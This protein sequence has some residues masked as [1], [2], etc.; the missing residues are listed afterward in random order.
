MGFADE[1]AMAERAI[2]GY[3]QDATPEEAFP[4][5]ALRIRRAREALGLTPD[6]VASRWGE[7]PSMYWDLEFHDDE[8]FTVISVRELHRLASVLQTSVEHLVFGEDPTPALPT[9]RYDDVIA[10]L[11]ARMVEDALSAE[12]LGDDIGWDLLPLLDDPDTLGDLPI[13]SVWSLCR[14]ANVDWVSVICRRPE[15]S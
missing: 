15:A 13:A 9:A 3:E 11:E 10:G 4:A 14:V 12:Q 1:R 8:A 5:I 6:D 7:E 2:A